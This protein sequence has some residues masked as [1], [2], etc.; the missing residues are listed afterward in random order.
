MQAGS[1]LRE[2]GAVLIINPMK[3][4]GIGNCDTCRKARKWLESS[5]H[6]YTWFDLREDAPDE[7]RIRH[8]AESVGLDKLVN[9]RSTTWRNLGEADRARAADPDAAPALLVQHPTLIKRP[10]FELGER[11]MVGFDASVRQSL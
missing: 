9:R 2:G 6:D 1:G 11:V 3:V 8:W 4:Y 10:L 7:A 5:G